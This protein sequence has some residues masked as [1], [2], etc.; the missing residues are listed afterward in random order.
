M[1]ATTP[2][3]MRHEELVPDRGPTD[4]QLAALRHYERL[5]YLFADAPE[6]MERAVQDLCDMGF[7]QIHPLSTS[8][9]LAGLKLKGRA[10]LA[11]YE[12]ISREASDRL[13]MKM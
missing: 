10:F 1:M 13:F 8:G 3:P 4:E 7:M 2:F 9:R 11:Q 5:P 12:N 6:G